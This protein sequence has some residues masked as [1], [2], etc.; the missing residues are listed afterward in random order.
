MGILPEFVGEQM[1]RMASIPYPTV[2]STVKTLYEYQG[3]PQWMYNV[4]EFLQDEILNRFCI[5]DLVEIR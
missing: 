1:H 3:P 5:I 2:D 4:I